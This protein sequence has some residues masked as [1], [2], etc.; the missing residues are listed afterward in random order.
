M[1]CFVVDRRHDEGAGVGRVL[2]GALAPAE[3]LL[4]VLVDGEIASRTFDQ[5]QDLVQPVL[6][7]DIGVD[8]RMVVHR[9]AV[10][11][12][13]VPDLGH[14]LVDI[15][16][17]RLLEALG[18]AA[19]GRLQQG[20]GQAQIGQRLGVMRMGLSQRRRCGQAERQTGNQD[21]TG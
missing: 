4:V 12:R 3:R 21:G 17:R 7:R 16:D 9:L 20:A 18:P 5:R 13:G 11:D 19:I 10:I 6:V 14:G 1:R 8:R 2:H 15:V